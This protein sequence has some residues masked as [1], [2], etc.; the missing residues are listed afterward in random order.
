MQLPEPETPVLVVF[1]KCKQHSEAALG[2]AFCSLLPY[3]SPLGLTGCLTYCYHT[4]PPC[5][6]TSLSSYTSC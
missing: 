4:P 6:S 1:V 3:L 2:V 5:R